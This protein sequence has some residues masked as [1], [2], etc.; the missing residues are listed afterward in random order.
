MDEIKE[1]DSKEVSED[2]E[3][4]EEVFEDTEKREVE[5]EEIFEDNKESTG[6]LLK[7]DNLTDDGTKEEVNAEETIVT[8]QVK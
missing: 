8:V 5:S 4:S 1:E 6:G 7:E 3:Y 2:E